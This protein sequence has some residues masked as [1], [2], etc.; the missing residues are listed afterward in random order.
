MEN[1][2][3]MNSRSNL[4]K[5]FTICLLAISSTQLSAQY[6][7]RIYDYIENTYVYEENQEEGHA[8]YLADEH[9]S[10]NGSWRFYFANTPEEVP[11]DFFL[12]NFKD[13]KWKRINV[14]SNWEMEGYGDPLFRNV[15]AP[16]KANP[17]YVPREYNP[18]GAYRRTFNLPADWKGKQVFLRMEKTQSA[19]FVWL[20]GKQ[21]GYN[22]GGQEPAEYDVTPYVK[23]GK[24]TLAVCVLKYCDGYYLEGQDYWRLAGIFDDVTL[25]ATPQTR[26][27]DWFVT[28]DLDE[29]YEDAE[30]KIAVD[31]KSYEEKNA[32]YAVRTTLTDANGTKVKEMT[33]ASFDMNGK[34]KKSLALSAH[35]DNPDKWT[36]ETPNLYNLKLE[37]LNASGKAIQQITSKMGFKETEIRNQTFFLNGKPIKVNATNTHMQ[38]PE[39]GHAMTEEIIRK[40]MEILKQHNFNAVRISHYPPVNKYLELADEYGLYIIDETGDEAHATEYVS[41]IQSFLPMYLERVRQMVLRDRNHVCVLFWSAGNESGEGPLITNVVEEGKKYDPTRFFMYGGNAYAHPAEDI[42]GPRYPTPYELEMNT[43]MTPEEEDPRPSFMDEYLSVA[44]NAGGGLDEYWDIIRRHPRLMG[45][46]LWDF[47]NPGLTDRIRPLTDS[48]PYNTPVHLM[49]N[50]KVEKGVLLLNGHDEWVEVYRNKNVEL[51]SNA[52]TISFDVKPGKLSGIH[53]GAAYITKGNTQFGV[54]QKGADKLQFYLH[55]GVKH[56]LDVDLPADWEGNWHHITA[57]WDSKEMK[58]Y[59]DGQLKG[60]EST[61]PKAPANNNR[62]GGGSPERGILSNFPYPINI[63]RFAGNH[64]QDPQTIYTADAEMDNVAIYNKCLADGEGTPEEAVL[65]LTF[66]G[67]GDEGTFYTIGGNM[68]TYGSIWPDRT[69]QPEM[70]QMKWT[71]Q[72]VSIRLLDADTGEAEV[73]NRLDFTD[74]SQYASHWALMADNEVLQEGDIQFS[75]AHQQKE[76]VKIP[77]HKPN[78]VAGKEYRIMITSTLKKDEIWA[79]AGHQVAWDQL[80]LTAWNM[81]APIEKRSSKA[82]KTE[83]D[84]KQI[85]IS[86]EGFCYVIDKESGNLSQIEV[87]GKALLKEPLTFNL[88][89]APLANEFDSW[90]AFRVNGGYA[91]GW[92]NMVSTLFYSKGLSQLKIRPAE[93]ALTQNE[94]ETTVNIHQL[95]QVGASSYGALDLYIQG[96]QLAGFS[97]DYTYHFYD[98]GTITISNHMSPQGKLPEMLPRIGFTTSI[99]NEFDQIIWYGRGPE[100]NYPDRK[101]G[102]P[103]GIWSKSVADMYEPYLLPQDHALRTDIRYLQLLNNEGNGVQISMDEHFNFNAYQFSTDNLTKSQ[104]TYQL[105]PQADRYTLN[106]DYATTGVGC[107]CVYVLDEYRVKPAAYSRTIT[108][109]PVVATK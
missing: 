22:E 19:S 91:E 17:P 81:P 51:T 89:R 92:G 54:V 25:Y 6:L 72:P 83:E 73:T 102:Y 61:A 31:V 12:P 28:T 55:S 56:T 4:K 29:A 9:L 34:G 5:L 78:I 30:L 74:L 63:G 26:L 14:P 96:V 70:L 65:Y 85:K 93:I 82:V 77:Y 36:A 66:D 103:V 106:L 45:G 99:A 40:D 37:L 1:T 105:Q 108:I 13:G 80:E 7:E 88:W 52:L 2:L 16:F 47:V 104:F 42:I 39:L 58:L 38:H 97:I 46:A 76:V 21:V 59:I 60:T 98:D 8:Y 109:K 23:P 24:N 50:A 57:S 18:T 68:R 87:G 100:E 69:P 41:N 95:V 15:A 44:G 107:T 49:G 43:A 48:S 79:K 53:E 64:A 101:T 94:Y 11:Q 71:T 62:R 20:N 32:T 84:E 35:I 75:A 67:N 33:S 27:F 86:G 90:N 3:F 10:L